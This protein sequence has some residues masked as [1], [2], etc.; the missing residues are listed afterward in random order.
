MN[1]HDAR[2][3]HT[4][5]VPSTAREARE[6]RPLERTRPVRR[7]LT[8]SI[9]A[10]RH[11]EHGSSLGDLWLRYSGVALTLAIVGAAGLAPWMPLPISHPTSFLLVA[12]VYTI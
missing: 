1:A 10:R 8:H 9:R 3:R 2:A 5:V 12:V 6:S 11:H 7:Y 4:A